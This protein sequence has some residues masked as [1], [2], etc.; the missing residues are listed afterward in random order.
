M[1]SLAHRQQLWGLRRAYNSGSSLD[2]SEFLDALHSEQVWEARSCSKQFGVFGVQKNW[3][4][5]ASCDFQGG[6]LPIEALNG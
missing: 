6:I 2:S 1:D 4:Y 5:Q 3:E